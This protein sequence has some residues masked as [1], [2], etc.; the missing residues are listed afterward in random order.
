ME[1][2]I[3]P[4]PTVLPTPTVSDTPSAAN[5]SGAAASPAPTS[6]AGTLFGFDPAVVIAI[7]LLVVASIGLVVSLRL[8]RR[9]GSH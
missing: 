6:P 9:P 1:P 3:A 5:P 2:S 4:G 7:G 8:S